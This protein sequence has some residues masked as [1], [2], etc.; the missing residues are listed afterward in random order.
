MDMSRLV[1]RFAGITCALLAL[2]LLA[3]GCGGGGE[4]DGSKVALLLPKESSLYKVSHRS[5]FEKA[6]EEKCGG[7][8]VLYSNAG[9]EASAQ[10][11]QAE[12]ALDKGAEV[13]VVDPVDPKAAAAIAAKAKTANVPVVSY[14]RL[15]ENGEVDAYVSF[16]DQ[17]TGEVA[18]QT[19][20]EKLEEGGQPSGPIIVINGPAGSA[21]AARIKTGARKA[22]E[23]AG[24]KIVREYDTPEWKAENALKETQRAL[25]GIGKDGFAAVYA[26][27][28]NTAA[29]A[30]S[31]VRYEG[32]GKNKRPVTGSGATFDAVQRIVAEEQFMTTYNQVGPEA[33]AAAE[34]AIAL[35]EGEGI[36]PGMV[37]GKVSNGQG[38]VPA[39][40]LKPIAITRDNVKDTVV[41]D[42]IV[43]TDELCEY[44]EYAC[45]ELKIPYSKRAP[46]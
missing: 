45:D 27:T 41:A 23:A 30:I 3:T 18:A 9:N 10:L 2:G 7:C 44:Y 35:A 21:K 12:A 39:V 20:A 15:I 14:D 8:E 4:E 31:V 42:G 34:I 26:A 25:A 6:V 36:P 29:G 22:F 13:L 24:V 5:A 1:G 28:N 40:L 16:D 38:N 19:L 17:M 32:L 43:E 46:S 37:T 11:R 33:T